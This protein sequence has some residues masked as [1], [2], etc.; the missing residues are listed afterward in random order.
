MGGWELIIGCSKTTISVGMSH[1]AGRAKSTLRIRQNA[2]PLLNEASGSWN[3]RCFE[4]RPLLVNLHIQILLKGN[5]V[6]SWSRSFVRLRRP[7]AAASRQPIFRRLSLE[8][9]R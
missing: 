3:T 5:P 1:A 7:I 6:G 8:I 4:S 9:R 2:M